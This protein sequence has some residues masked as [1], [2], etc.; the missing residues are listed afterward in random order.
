MR[1]K[2]ELTVGARPGPGDHDDKEGAILNRSTRWCKD[3]EYEADP[4]QGEKLIH[5]FGLGGAK[6]AVTPGLQITAEELSKDAPDEKGKRKFFRGSAAIATYLSAD[7]I[8]LNF[9]ATEICRFMSTPTEGGI[10]GSTRFGRYLGG[11][12]RLLYTY[13]RQT[14]EKIDIYSDTRKS[15]SGGC[16]MSGKHV[17]RHGPRRNPTKGFHPQKRGIMVWQRPPV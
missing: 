14:V 15:T 12:K 5:E 9:A 1:I 7:M 2:Y 17:K 3:S 8:D 13:P 16:I 11:K 6:P 10:R 4:R